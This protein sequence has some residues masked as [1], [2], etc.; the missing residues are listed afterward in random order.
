MTTPNRDPA[1]STA[2]SFASG[3]RRALNGPPLLGTSSRQIGLV[4]AT[5]LGWG[6]ARALGTSAPV[7][8]RRLSLPATIAETIARVTATNARGP[9]FTR[10]AYDACR[11]EHRR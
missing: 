1:D 8:A 3:E 4:A 9:R 6:V 11:L 10:S 7:S 2:T 5:P